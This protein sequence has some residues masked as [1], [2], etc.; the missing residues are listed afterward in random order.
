MMDS[1]PE[2]KL[3]TR[4][5][6]KQVSPL[7]AGIVQWEFGTDFSHTQQ[8]QQQQHQQ[9]QQGD[10]DDEF[11]AR[12]L[13]FVHWGSAWVFAAKG[14]STLDRCDALNITVAL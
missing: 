6:L 5:K 12:I 11:N 13:L 7:R 2:I 4:R 10:D 8:R 9:Q 14:I 3:K 1:L